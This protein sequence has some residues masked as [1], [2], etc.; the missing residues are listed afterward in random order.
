M[1]PY[2]WQTDTAIGKRSWG[3]TTDNEFKSAYNIVTTLIDIVSKNGMLLL[4]IGPKPDGTFTA[5]ETKVLSEL[6]AWLKTNGEGIYETVP[7]K[8]YKEGETTASSG[9]FSEGDVAYTE[10]DFRFTYKNGA[11]YVFQMK[12]SQ[13][14]EIKSLHTDR[15]GICI[16]NISILGDNEVESCHCGTDGVTVQLKKAPDGNLPLC[17]KV[18]LG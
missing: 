14:I 1:F 12:P 16:E 4:N 15:C 11:L 3:Y 9:M 8:F 7:Y 2:P 10:H 18:E 5:E 6:G 13:T 17:L